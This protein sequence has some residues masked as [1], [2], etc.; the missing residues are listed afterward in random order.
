MSQLSILSYLVDGRIGARSEEA[1][2]HAVNAIESGEVDVVSGQGTGMD[3]GPYYL[4]SGEVLPPSRPILSRSSWPRSA[5]ASRSYSPWAGPQA[6]TF[7][8]S[9]I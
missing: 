3:A 6:R 7:T 4:G 8:C 9:L 1:I 5:V 2:Q